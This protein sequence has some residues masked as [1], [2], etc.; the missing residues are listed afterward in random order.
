MQESTNKY[1]SA[2]VFPIEHGIPPLAAHILESS[3][4]LGPAEGRVPV[5]P[6][7]GGGLP[8]EVLLVDRRAPHPGRTSRHPAAGLGNPDPHALGLGT[9][10]RHA[11]HP[12]LDLLAPGTRVL[13]PGRALGAH[14]RATAWWRTA[15]Q[16]VRRVTPV[17]LPVQCYAGYFDRA[18]WL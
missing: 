11:G 12:D 9:G 13:A 10:A 1:A 8:V 5:P 14:L 16:T 2:P 17:E 15:Q 6:V 4:D 18:T 7:Q 3:L